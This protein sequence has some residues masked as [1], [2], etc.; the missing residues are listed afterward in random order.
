MRPLTSRIF[1]AVLVAAAFAVSAAQAKPNFSG[2]WKLNVSKSD[3]GPMPAPDSRTDKITHDDPSLRDEI[4]QSSQ[5]GD[6]TSDM[7]YSTDGKETTNSIAGNEIKTTAKWDGDDLVITGKGSFNG[8]DVTFDSHWSLAADG[9][10]ITVKQHVT[11]P[12]GEADLKMV[13]DKQ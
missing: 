1:C 12:M 6:M 5:M 3:F 4:S 10:T 11:S 8:A 13:M 2:T 7:K 9:K